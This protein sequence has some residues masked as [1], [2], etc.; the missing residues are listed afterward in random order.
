MQNAP[1]LKSTHECEQDIK[2]NQVHKTVCSE[3]LMFRPFSKDGNG[4]V[5]TATQTLTYSTYKTSTSVSQGEKICNFNCLLYVVLIIY[6]I[7]SL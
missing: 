3:E 5:T 4:A 2:S 6:H 7:K 1:L